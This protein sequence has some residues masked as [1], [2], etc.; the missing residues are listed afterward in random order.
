EV[1]FSSTVRSAD[2]IATE[3][4]NQNSP[5]SFY[6]MGSA[7]SGVPAP[8]IISLSSDSGSVGDFL[9]ITG[10]NFGS[11]QGTSTVTFNGLTASVS[12][13]SSTSIVTTVPLGATSGNVVVTVDGL[14]SSGEYSDNS[15]SFTVYSAPAWANGYTYR[16]TITLNSAYV[17]SDQTNFP[18]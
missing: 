6:T 12:S 10:F 7:L 14:T 13:W 15:P 4:N 3:Y 16:R 5:S 18:V 9:T 17:P 2:W 8:V 11:T 1:R